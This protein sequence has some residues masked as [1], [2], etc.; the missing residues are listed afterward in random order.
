MQLIAK[1]AG[2]TRYNLYKYFSSKEEI[3]L[4]FLKHDI[5]LWRQDL[6]KTCRRRKASSVETFAIV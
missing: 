6:V 3:F 5:I 2:F 1:E 4:E